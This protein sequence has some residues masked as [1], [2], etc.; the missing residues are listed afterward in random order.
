MALKPGLDSGVL[1]N[2]ALQESPCVL[3]IF[4][5]RLTLDINFPPFCTPVDDTDLGLGLVC[6]RFL[7]NLR[8]EA[9]LGEHIVH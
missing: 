8:A 4:R 9:W 2:N 5:R 3:V 7:C 1:W 6:N